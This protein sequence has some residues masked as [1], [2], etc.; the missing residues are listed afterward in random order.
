MLIAQ[1]AAAFAWWHGCDWPDCSSSL[2]WVEQQLGRK[3]TAMPGWA[4]AA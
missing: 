4:A 3:A 1:G 2:G